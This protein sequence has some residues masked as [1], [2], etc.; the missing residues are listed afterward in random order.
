VLIHFSQRHL[1]SGAF[2]AEARAIFPNVIAAHD[3]RVAPPPPTLD[4]R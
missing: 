2:V 1:G 3:L 4:S